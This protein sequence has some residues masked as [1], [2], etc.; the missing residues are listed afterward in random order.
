MVARLLA[1]RGFDVEVIVFQP[2]DFSADELRTIGIPI[3]VLEPRNVVDLVLLMRRTLSDSRPDVVLAF[4]K[5]SSLVVELAGAWRRDYGVVVSERSLDESGSSIIRFLR[6]SAHWL[7]DAIVCNS[8][9][10]HGQLCRLVPWLRGR[11]S[12]IVNG[13]DLSRFSYSRKAPR[14]TRGRVRMLVLARYATQKNPF[15]LLCAVAILRERMPGLKL[16]VDW[17]GYLPTTEERPDGRLSA[18]YRS[19]LAARAI[20]DR[21]KTQIDHHLLR[22]RV[23]LHG[24]RSDVVSLYRSCD[25]VCLPSF[26]E[27]CSNVIAEAL[28]C[29][30]PILASDV[31]DNGRLVTDGV[32]GFLF[33]PHRPSDIASAAAP[34]RR[35]GRNRV[36][37]NEQGVPEAS[38]RAPRTERS[39]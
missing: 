10:Q 30:V 4:L 9:S 33:D 22:D 38:R 1:E 29:G 32:T 3:S 31:S 2:N 26:Y 36:E 16:M 27:G 24:V 21:M 17:Y 7:A 12:V 15:G 19:E 35:T 18:H 28:S 8:Y 39:G 6:Y 25:V 34:I 20:H 37:S 23:R 5:W 13:V 14:S 11:T